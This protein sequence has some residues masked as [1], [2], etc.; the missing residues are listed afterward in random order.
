MRLPQFTPE[1]KEEK[2]IA[3]KEKCKW[4]SEVCCKAFQ[5]TVPGWEGQEAWMKPGS[6]CMAACW[7]LGGFVILS[8]PLPYY[9][10]L[11]VLIFEIL[12]CCKVFLM[13]N[14]RNLREENRTL[15][16]L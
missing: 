7:S 5:G 16:K 12:L 8:L 10:F 1:T 15:W 3:D 11:C 4:L 14:K 2:E 13:L 6:P 9:Y